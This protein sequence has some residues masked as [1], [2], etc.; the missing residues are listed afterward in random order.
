MAFRSIGFVGAL[1][2]DALK[3]ARAGPIEALMAAG[4]SSE[5]GAALYTTTC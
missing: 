4:A 1:F 2:G 3:V 5:S